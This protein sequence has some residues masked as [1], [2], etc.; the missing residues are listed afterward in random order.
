MFFTSISHIIMTK[1]RLGS[2]KVVFL[3]RF[4]FNFVLHVLLPISLSINF[5]FSFYLVWLIVCGAIAELLHYP[6]MARG[7]SHEM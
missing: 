7:V 1:K 5:P 4:P 2:F 6:V 3:F